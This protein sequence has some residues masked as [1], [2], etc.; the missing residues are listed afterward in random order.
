MVFPLNS[1]T[2]KQEKRSPTYA[3]TMETKNSAV[4]NA[5]FDSVSS[6]QYPK[7]NAFDS[8]IGHD[9]SNHYVS[10]LNASS[11]IN[12]RVGPSILL[13][14]MAG[15]TLTASTM[16]WYQGAV[17][18]PGSEPS[19]LNSLGTLVATDVLGVPNSKFVQA[20]QAALTTAVGPGLTSFLSAKDAAFVNTAPK[21]FL[22]WAL[23]DD[24]FN[25]VQGGVTQ[26]PTMT[27]G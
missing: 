9:T 12:Q 24:R 26:I 13:R 17:Q 25:Y 4:E 1:E 16:A 6:T 15:D 19:L 5:L 27:A 20:Q 8:S 23:L 2:N 7:P 3:A 14:V 21:A 10:R 18:Q 22:N 11:S